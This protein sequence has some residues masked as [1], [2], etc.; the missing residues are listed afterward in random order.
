MKIV[1]TTFSRVDGR[2]NRRYAM[3][4]LVVVLDGREYRTL[5][6]SLG[7]FRLGGFAEPTAIATRITGELRPDDAA[8]PTG[9]RAEIVRVDAEA[10]EMAARFVEPD[11]ALIGR[12]DGAIARRLHRASRAGDSLA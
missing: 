1:R 11:E 5:D 2:R 7:G 10:S 3:P 12:L 8:A 9:F 6:W 4:P